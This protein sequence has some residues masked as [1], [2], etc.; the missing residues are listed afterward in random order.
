MDAQRPAGSTLLYHYARLIELMSCL[1]RAEKLLKASVI[2][3]KDI[4]V[5]VRFQ[6]KKASGLSRRQEGTLIHHYQVDRYGAIQT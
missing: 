3:G 1:E 5:T 4:R 6:R 2:C